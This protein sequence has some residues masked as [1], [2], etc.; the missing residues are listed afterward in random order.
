MLL[1]HHNGLSRMLFSDGQGI[2]TRL[3]LS[4]RWVR[5]REPGPQWRIRMS[6]SVLSPTHLFFILWFVLVCSGG[7]TCLLENYFGNLRDLC[8]LS[9]GNRDTDLRTKERGLNEMDYHHHH[10]HRW[11]L[12]ELWWSETLPEKQTKSTWQ[13]GENEDHVNAK[14]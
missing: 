6:S 1:F 2:R 10:H 11:F 5:K 8:S 4:W 9:I 14:I 13:L 7:H 12:I 3:L